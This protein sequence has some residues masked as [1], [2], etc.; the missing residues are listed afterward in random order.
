[1]SLKEQ[2]HEVKSKAYAE[3]IRYM[4]NAKD[5]L[6]KA[7]KDGKYYS[8]RKYVRM[9]CGTAYSGILVAL[10]AY[11]VLKGVPETKKKSIDFYRKNIAL[12]DKSLLRDL[13]SAYDILHL[14]G[15]YEGRLRA[16]AIKLGLDIAYEI[17]D[18]ISPPD[19]TSYPAATPRRPAQPI[20]SGALFVPS[21]LLW[22]AGFLRLAANAFAAS[23]ELRLPSRSFSANGFFIICAALGAV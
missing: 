14:D 3:A 16:D 2:Q 13:N 1:M 6:R 20:F 19:G 11:L 9:A 15:Y 7:N 23:Y 18:Q 10:D 12:L 21:L 8:D 17:I 4:D 22:V 5:V